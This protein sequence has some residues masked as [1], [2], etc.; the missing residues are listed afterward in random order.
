MRRLYFAVPVRLQRL[1]RV[2]KRC[3]SE[4]VSKYRVFDST[5]FERKRSGQ[6]Q[7]VAAIRSSRDHQLRDQ[8]QFWVQTRPCCKT[9]KQIG[10]EGA[11]LAA[12][13]IGHPRL[14]NS[15]N[16]RRFIL[17]HTRVCQP[18]SETLE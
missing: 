14:R 6:L 11:D 7:L 17:G 4:C 16:L 8:L 3:V 12:L 9:N 1:T 2:T 15:E 18:A 10:A 13:D 5:H